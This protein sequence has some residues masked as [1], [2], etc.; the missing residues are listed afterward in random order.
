MAIRKDVFICES[1]DE[2]TTVGDALIADGYRGM[3]RDAVAYGDPESVAEQLAVFADLGFTDVT[4]R[5]MAVPQPDAVR[6][7]EL[8]GRVRTLLAGA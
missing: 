8:A 4:I 5:T 7:I 6:S 1:D 2:A 3:G